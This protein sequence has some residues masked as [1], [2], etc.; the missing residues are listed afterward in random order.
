MEGVRVKDLVR[1]TKGRL[2]SGTKEEEISSISIDSRTLKKGDFFVP[3]KGESFDG[4]NF[5]DEALKK[6]A[7][8]FLTES[9]I[10]NPKS[11]IPKEKVIIVVK[12]TRKALG[13]I[14]LGYRKL[15]SIPLI[16]I[17]GSAGK[18]MTREMTASL[19][20]TNFSVLKSPRNF[21]ND[22]GLPLTLFQIKKG[23]EVVIVEIGVSK[24][25]EMK[26]L[27]EI[28]SPNFGL[29]TA[30]Y[31]AH[32]GFFKSQKELASEKG[33]LLNYLDK[34]AFL[35]QDSRYFSILSQRCPVKFRTFGV[36]RRADFFATQITI[37]EKGIKFLL[38]D[39]L[40]IFLPVP[41]SFL[42]YNVL[43]AIAIAKEFGIADKKIQKT[44]SSFSPLSQRFSL[45][46]FNG[47][48]IVDDTYNANPISFRMAVKELKRFSAK[49]RIVVAGEMRELGRFKR[50]AHYN[51]G[52]F[53]SKNSD[54]IFIIGEGARE[55]Y[56][57][58]K[59]EGLSHT[60][61]YKEKEEAGK[62]L[63]RMIR[64]GDL[65]LIKGSRAA[66]LEEICSIISS[67]H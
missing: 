14:A 49:R 36:K 58:A 21:N 61:F 9:Q 66:K 18:T 25:G 55:I 45:S 4:H 13:D 52:R 40:P 67:I 48:R 56:E 20:S 19:L 38:N 39:K 62:R 8:G 12:D 53:L 65:I 54:L 50:R 10:P 3:L 51:L 5:I 24:K 26:R 23:K 11:Q 41:A 31:P 57:G 44:L 16:A 33:K 28:A 6:G 47:I 63:K 22:I 34:G 59:D 7:K 43:G 37:S 27:C 2:S 42:V 15:F 17:S 1:W 60:F 46:S 35:N 32:L 29:I 64:K 30:I